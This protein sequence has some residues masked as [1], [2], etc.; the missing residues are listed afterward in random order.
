MNYN[1]LQYSRLDKHFRPI[2]M[3]LSRRVLPQLFANNIVG[4]QPMSA[5]VGI[6]YAMRTTY[7]TPG[8]ATFNVVPEPNST[9][10]QKQKRRTKKR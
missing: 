7:S 3:S 4:V 8:A 9:K 10:P 5:P 6:A 1:R 2:A